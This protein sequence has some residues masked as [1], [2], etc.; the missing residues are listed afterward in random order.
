[1][2]ESTPDTDLQFPNP[3]RTGRHLYA[4]ARFDGPGLSDEPTDAFILTRGYWTEAEAQQQA[5]RLNTSAQ[6]QPGVRY[7]VL[8]VRVED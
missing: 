7:F 2:N 6:E 4:V 5:R 1:V 3:P 8:P